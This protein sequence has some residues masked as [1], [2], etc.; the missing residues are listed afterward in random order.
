MKQEA[1]TTARERILDTASRLFY[2]HGVRAT[3]VDRIIA[4]SG[5]AKMSFYRNFASKKDLVR[6]FLERRS[7]LWM[8]WF[9][10]R[11]VELEKARPG[12]SLS[13]MAQVLHE[14][15][16][17][18]DFRGCSFINIALEVRD[19]DA[20]EHSI[21]RRHKQD[22]GD[23]IQGRLAPAAPERAEEI[24]RLALLIL[25]GAIVRAQITG[26]AAA[27]QEAGVLFGLLEQKMRE[28]QE[29]GEEAA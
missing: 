10:R 13:V 12:H 18:A 24:A 27:A 19:L 1:H 7:G 6:A 25:D 11:V 22:L 2:A 14:W 20:D 17:E 3:G 15:F 29:N 23:F 5:V 21:A 28:D 26:S 4:E 9:T 16:E 8:G